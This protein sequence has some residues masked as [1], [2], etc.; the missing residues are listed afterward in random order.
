VDQSE[1]KNSAQRQ[2]IFP[3]PNDNQVLGST[4]T[5]NKM[6][7]KNSAV[8]QPIPVYP[9]P[10][11]NQSQ[12]QNE[13]REMYFSHV[14]QQNIPSTMTYLSPSQN[15][16]PVTTPFVTPTLLNQV[17]V[18]RRPSPRSDGETDKSGDEG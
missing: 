17:P 7:V 8:V 1:N 3:Q 2:I 18:I 4:T 14:Y 11:P 13:S 6:I 12:I 15:N 5:D 10:I 9:S 16:R